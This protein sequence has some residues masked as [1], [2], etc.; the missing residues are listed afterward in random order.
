VPA[1]KPEGGNGKPVSNFARL[2]QILKN[3]L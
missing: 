2:I 1:E 3:R